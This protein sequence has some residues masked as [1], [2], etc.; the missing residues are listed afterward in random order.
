MEIEDYVDRLTGEVR[1][2]GFPRTARMATRVITEVTMLS[3]TKQAHKDE[4]DI[5]KIHERVMKTGQIPGHL[6]REGV[7]GD[8]TQAGDLQE[9]L[10]RVQQ[11]REDFDALPSAVRDFADNDPVRLLEIVGD[12]EFAEEAREAGLGSLMEYFHGPHEPSEPDVQPA[13]AGSGQRPAASGEKPADAGEP[14]SSSR[15]K[16]GD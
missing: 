7:F 15:S 4:C 5:R 1:P 8:F 16:K 10:E 9:A 3:R 2:F 6:V 13:D 12:P 14:P 11:A